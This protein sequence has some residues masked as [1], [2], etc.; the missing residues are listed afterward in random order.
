MLGVYSGQNTKKFR[1]LK[2]DF[3]AKLSVRDMLYTLY[4]LSLSI[5][6][7]FIFNIHVCLT[8]VYMTAHVREMKIKILILAIGE[9]RFF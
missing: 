5:F 6:Y 2:I 1:S 9:N 8:H 3:K 7:S 4:R